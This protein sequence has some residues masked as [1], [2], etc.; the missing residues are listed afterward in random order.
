MGKHDKDIE[1]IAAEGAGARLIAT[2]LN[3]NVGYVSR[4]LKKMGLQRDVGSNQT[5][6]LTGSLDIVFENSC[7]KLSRTSEL[8]FEYLCSK[9]GFECAVPNSTVAY[10]YLVNFGNGWSK[11]QVKSSNSCVFNLARSRHN[12]TSSKSLLY[13]NDEV[14]YFFLHNVDGRCWL[15]PFCLLEG[16]TTIKPNTVCTNY[17]IVETRR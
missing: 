16:K 4:R 15:I 17:Q 6:P 5:R 11:V 12:A 10:D 1:S 3:L 9:Y 7:E 13:S 2:R 8:F 14:D